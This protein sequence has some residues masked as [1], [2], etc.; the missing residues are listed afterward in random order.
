VFLEA[1]TS[2]EAHQAHESTEHI[3]R[4]IQDGPTLTSQ[5]VTVVHLRKLA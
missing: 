3:R 5:P 2:Q 4:I 1:W